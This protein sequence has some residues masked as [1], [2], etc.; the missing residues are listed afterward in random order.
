MEYEYQVYLE[1]N[2]KGEI[3]VEERKQNILIVHNYYQISGGEDTVVANEKKMLEDHGHK[4]ILYTRNNSELKEM[5]KFQKLKLP[6]TTIFNPRTYKDI[7]RI[8]RKENIDVVHVHNTLNL[9]S[10]AVYYAALSC[11]LPVVQTVHNFRLLCPGATFYRDGHICEDCVH[12]GLKCAIK[13]NCYRGSKVQTLVCVVNTWIHR[14]T[15]VYGKINYICLTEF[16]KQKLLE[17]KQIKEDKVFVKPNFV[18][19]KEKFV[20]EEQR[21]DQFVFAGRLDKLKGIDILLKAWK[22]MGEE[23]PK[24]VVCGTGPMEKWCREFAESNNL[25]VEFKGFVQNAEVLKIVAS[26]KALVLPTQC[27]EGFP[28]SIVEAFSVGTPVICSDLGNAGSIVEEKVTGFKFQYNES[29]SLKCVIKEFES[30]DMKLLQQSAYGK[31]RRYFD[32]NRN[33]EMIQ[34]IYSEAIGERK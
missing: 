23:A 26:S 16:N 14:M 1:C 22:Q 5:S 15:G 24:L 18:E 31:Y 10:P 3:S 4:V 33:Y 7:K 12:H 13:N 20:P 34:A 21:K 30:Y 28:M 6:F 8:I 9:V 32:Q 2:D 27:Y 25:N 17:L 29:D 19:S 11:K